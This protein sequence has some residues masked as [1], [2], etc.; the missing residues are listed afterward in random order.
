MLT[1]ESVPNT[2]VE[3][4]EVVG[5]TI[6]VS[7]GMLVRVT[8]TGNQTVLQVIVELVRAAQS[9]KA[10]I[11]RL[12]DRVAAVFVPVV[13]GIALVTFAVWWSLIPNAA[14]LSRGV[15]AAVTVLVISC[16]CALGLATP[17]AMMTAMGHSAELGLLIKDAATIELAA[18]VDTVV[19]DK[20]GTLTRGVLSV[21]DVQV[22][23]GWTENE[24]LRS[25]A[26][27]EQHSE[28]PIARAIVATAT[29]RFT[30]TQ[31]VPETSNGLLPVMEP[32]RVDRPHLPQ[33]TAFENVEGMG[34]RGLVGGVPVVIGNLAYLQ[35][36]RVD[37][38]D[39][40][41]STRDSGRTEP[42]YGPSIH[43]AVNGERAGSIRF[44]D[45]PKPDARA[46]VS[47]L[48][49]MGLEVVLLTGDHPVNAKAVGQALG[50]ESVFGGV[51]PAGKVSQIERL[52]DDGRIVAMVGDGINDAPALA[53]ADVSIA[54]GSGTDVAI[55]AA[56]MTLISPEVAAVARGLRL[57]RR[58]MR[59]VRQNLFFAF[60]YNLIGIPFAAGL[61]YPFTG[62]M[63]PP[64]FAAA[65]MSLSSVSVVTNSLRLR[66]VE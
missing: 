9:S 40:E 19:F 52:K 65:A 51:L 26:A 3:G 22:C 17:T 15:L 1:G 46:T 58:T 48:R 16:P 45:E 24:L 61:F 25:A 41:R 5:G 42:E 66:Q 14:G 47:E 10:P 56:G 54:L 6:N 32:P 29:S 21:I 64:M 43:M 23:E 35:Q 2:R 38:S 60:I 50:I 53:K 8:R 11:A 20:T 39:L 44:A 55:A 62:W 36:H 18:Q 13:V 12:A 34:A 59:I 49:Q 30:P 28:H 7:G 31:S 57:A 33:A 37:I 27:V 4:D 63:L